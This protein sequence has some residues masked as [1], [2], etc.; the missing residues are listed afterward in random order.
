MVPGAQEAGVSV[1]GARKFSQLPH[2]LLAA[3]RVL[4]QSGDLLRIV[5]KTLA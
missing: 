5:W 3:G 2:D 4:Q 1:I